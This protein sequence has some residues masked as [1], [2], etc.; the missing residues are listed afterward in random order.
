LKK[1]KKSALKTLELKPA[2]YYLNEQE[3]DV[4]NED[5]NSLIKNTSHEVVYLDP[6]YNHRQY[7]GNYHILETIAKYDNPKIR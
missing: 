1:L 2:N 6:P 7:S 5:I 4:F 3:H